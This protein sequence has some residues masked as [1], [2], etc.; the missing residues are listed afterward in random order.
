MFSAPRSGIAGSCSMSVLNIFEELPD[1]FPEWLRCFTFSHQQF[2]RIPI[3]PHPYQHMLFSII[4]AVAIL[5]GVQWYLI[6]KSLITYMTC[7]CFLPFHCVGCHSTFLI[8]VFG[9]TKIFNLNQSTFFF[10]LDAYAFR[11]HLRN[12]CLNSRSQGFTPVFYSKSFIVIVLYVSS[13]H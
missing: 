3:S 9:S 5:V 2:V 12:H 4:L 7:K 8:I 13:G 11:L 1:G 6:V 10:S